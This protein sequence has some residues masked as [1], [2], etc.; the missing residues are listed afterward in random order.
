VEL[1]LYRPGF[2]T[3]GAEPLIDAI[4]RGH[5]RVFPEPPAIVADAVS[6]MWRDTNAF[7]ELGIPAVSYA[8]RSRSHAARK[9]FLIS[10]LVDAA[11]VY[12]H[13]ALDLCNRDREPWLPLGCHVNRDLAAEV[14]ARRT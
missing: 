11:R 8:P 14:A 9:S 4:R 13:I 1:F 12:A 6:S 7:N 2:E 10:D 3:K 5:A